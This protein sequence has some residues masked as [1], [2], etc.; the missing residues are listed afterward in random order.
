MSNFR[1]L[2]QTNSK[3]TSGS[4]FIEPVHIDDRPSR[5]LRNPSLPSRKFSFPISKIWGQFHQRSTC[6]F[7]IRKLCAQLF[8]AYVLGLY[9]TGVR[10]LVQK[11][12]IERLWNW[13]QVKIL[14]LKILR[15]TRVL[16]IKVDKKCLVHIGRNG[17]KTFMSTKIA[18]DIR[19]TKLLATKVEKIVT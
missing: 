10:L 9:F 5:L 4:Y 13:P 19:S 14:R 18:L 17:K 6:S 8:C 2:F 16:D 12:C 15:S 11:L 7:Y 3:F 1:Q